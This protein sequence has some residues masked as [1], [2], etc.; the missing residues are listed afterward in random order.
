MSE[1]YTDQRFDA[2]LRDCI[3]FHCVV[4]FAMLQ[5]GR[6]IPNPI[7]TLL[8]LIFT[9]PRISSEICYADRI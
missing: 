6:G 4:S 3:E 5:T 7:K 8:Q 2:S 1:F 9:P